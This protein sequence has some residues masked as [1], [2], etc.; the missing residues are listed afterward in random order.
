MKTRIATLSLLLFCSGLTA[1]TI[2]VGWMRE[3]RLVFGAST[4]ASAAVVA[5]FMGGLGIGNALLG[6]RADRVESPLLMYAVLEL[7]VGLTA[8]LSPFLIDLVRAIYI[9]FGGQSV[10][11]LGGATLMRLGLAATVLAAP[12]ILM[13]GTL[14][15]AI[16]AAI[17]A[18]DP[19]RRGAGL[20]Y[21]ANTLGAVAGAAASTFLLLPS[22]GT[23]T[24]LWLGCLLSVFV[25]AVAWHLA[26]RARIT[27]SEQE[28]V[29]ACKPA[30]SLCAVNED[31][32]AFCPP[33]RSIAR[34]WVYFA[35]A[36]VGF[37]FFLMEVVW[38][39]MLGPILGGTTYTFGLILAVA[40]L[41]IGIGG[42]LYAPL[43]RGGKVSVQ[44]FALSCGLEAALLALP[45]ALGDRLAILAAEYHAA[46]R[47]FGES[48][49][50]WAIVAGVTILPAAIVSGIQFPILIALLGRGDRHVG[51][52]VGCAFAWN[53]CG[54]ILGS[55]A[56]GFGILPLLSAPGA[57]LAVILLLAMLAMVAAAWSFRFEGERLLP[58]IVTGLAAATLLVFRAE[59][60]T[61]AWRH[62]GIGAGRFALP[63]GN[64]NVLRDWIYAQR[65]HV[66]WEAEGVEAGIAL[67]AQDGLSFF[68][69]G[70]CDG[71][72]IGD[73]GTQLVSGV[74]AAMLHPN[75]KSA[76]IVGLGTGETPGWLAQVP[77][78]ARVDVV[79]LEP[80]I[81]KMARLC[82]HV[83]HDVLNH[84]KVH[85]IYD[86]AREVL[87][88]TPTR[89]DLIFSEPSNPYRAGIANL[90]T[91][92]FYLSSRQ[93]L[94]EGGLFIQW[95]QG[96][97]IDEQTVTTICA[98]LA[99]VF[100][101]VEI[102]QSKAEDMLMVCSQQPIDIPADL[103]RRR[104]KGEPFRSAF[105]WGWRAT[106]LEGVLARYVAGPGLVREMIRD[107]DAVNSDDHN[108]VEYGFARTVGNPST[109]FSVRALRKA[110]I[111]RGYHRPS[112]VDGDVDWKRVDDNRQLLQ[113]LATGEV[114]LPPEPSAEQQARTA[115][116]RLYWEGDAAGMVTA[117]K[118]AGYEPVFPSETAILALACAHVGDPQARELLARLAEFDPIEAAAIEAHLL[119]R[120]NRYP[121]AAER[122]TRV[123][124]AFRLHPWCLS[125][126]TEMVFP[127]VLTLAARQPASAT[128]LFAALSRPFAAYLHEE[129]RLA[130]AHRVAALLGPQAVT[131][132]LQAY[133][134]NVPWNE[135]FLENRY[136]VYQVIRHPLTC[137]AQDDLH[138]F[139]R[140]E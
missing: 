87:L 120:Q 5:I 25:A 7:G 16:R 59:G 42:A 28:Q 107:I 14:P 140:W 123:L 8:A 43:F 86:D 131:E 26:R 115:A 102:W 100:A 62:S 96:Y 74:F 54:A 51:R 56:G 18:Q 72:A 46:S 118:S 68:I 22:V 122:M 95:V 85:I 116:L 47:S 113:A 97:E 99:S 53:T 93:R 66:L 137:R 55:L 44:S 124:H 109:G 35:A 76:F 89:Y 20:L 1:L 83:N 4:A 23:R 36:A 111:A 38:Y 105:A 127:D 135:A 39:R 138:T 75:P 92:E 112:L 29:A 27:S 117:W 130:T 11:G 45:F 88:T 9:A 136:R 78:M 129:D 70:K 52:Q 21:G 13:G 106:D 108:L 37:A 69:N 125:H 32:R 57:W 63:E 80:A 10:L 94:N 84:P 104:M 79:E 12:T 98:T 50:G 48:V 103:C 133:E 41:G 67:V 40:L 121:E 3:F 73:A 15:A 17:T 77:T 91:R 134:P 126:V 34:H 2:Q 132:I 58:A 110:A 33:H 119:L 90:F 81:D 64:D 24:T 61:A 82:R 128:R 6:R 114:F 30:S 139:R 60:P 71:N 101:H 65:R 19:Q 49:W 31:V